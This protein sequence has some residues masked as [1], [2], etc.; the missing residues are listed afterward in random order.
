[1]RSLHMVSRSRSAGVRMTVQNVSISAPAK[2]WK[3]SN[4][5][6]KKTDP[7]SL[8][9]R[10]AIRWE[11]PLSKNWAVK[12]LA[13][14]VWL[15]VLS[16]ALNTYCKPT[17]INKPGSW[18]FVFPDHIERRTCSPLAGQ[19]KYAFHCISNKTGIHPLQIESFNQTM[20][21]LQS[22]QSNSQ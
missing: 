17:M 11:A 20:I 18:S 2:L 19:W 4:G 10:S 6:S 22:I 5:Q 7:K 15:S 13:G 8:I 14:Y 1:M 9:I 21:V 3:T 16:D 12:T